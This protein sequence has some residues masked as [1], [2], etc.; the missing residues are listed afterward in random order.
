MKI[1]FRH[2]I[3]KIIEPPLYEN[4]PMISSVI[5]DDVKIKVIKSE[6][7][8]ILDTNL[9]FVDEYKKRFNSVLEFYKD[10]VDFDDTNILE[11]EDCNLFR[12]WCGKYYYELN[13]VNRIQDT[14]SLGLFLLQLNKFKNT[15]LPAIK[16]K[17]KLL[18]SVITGYF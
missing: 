12:E 8:T 15:I 9:H 2:Y 17:I 1:I 16:T 10:I 3:N 6:I 4:A 18:Q 13:S 11:N 5:K 7:K 14:Q